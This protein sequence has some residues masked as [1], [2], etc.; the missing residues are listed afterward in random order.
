MSKDDRIGNKYIRYGIVTF[1]IFSLLT[2]VITIVDAKKLPDEHSN[3]GDK[4]SDKCKDCHDKKDVKSMVSKSVTT[5]DKSVITVDK[6]VTSEYNR[7]VMTV[8]SVGSTLKGM[9]SSGNYTTL[10]EVGQTPQQ[11]GI[12]FRQ[13]AYNQFNGWT[14]WDMIDF[15]EEIQKNLIVLTIFDNSTGTIKPIAGLT[16]A[17]IW[18]L[19]SFRNHSGVYSYKADIAL[20]PITGQT[21][22]PDQKDI[23]MIKEI[24]LTNI[25]SNTDLTFWTWYSMEVDWDYGYVMVSTDGG[26]NWIN[27]P[28]TYTNNTNPNG[29]NNGN[30]ITGSSPDWVQETMDLTPYIGNKIFLGFRFK[31]DAA[32][33]GEGLYI[34][35][36]S[37]TSGGITIFS[38]DAEIIPEIKTLSVNVTYPY[39][40]IGNLTN[41]LTNNA[42][43]QYTQ[44]VQKVDMYEVINHPGTY[45]GYFKYDTFGGQYPGT[46]DIMLDTYINNDHII[47]T[48][49]FQ[50]TT[51][52]CIGCHNKV[53]DNEETSFLHGGS[54]GG[55]MGSCMYI[56]HS[57]S[58]G[59]YFVPEITA[60]PMHLHEMKYGHKNGFIPGA[61]GNPQLDYNVSSH[62]TNT[63]CQECH[64]SFIHDNTGTDIFKI[65][66]YTIYGTNVTFSGGTHANL[67]CEY[68]HGNLN[69]P[70][71]PQSQHVLNGVLGDY[72]PSF[73]SH[74][75][76]A[77][78]YVIDVNGNVNLTINITG[79]D[80]SKWVLLHLVGPV[81]NTT[82][83]LQGSYGT[84]KG[85]LEL[86]QSLSTPIN[87][88]IPSPYIGTW[89]AKINHLQEGLIN[90]TIESNYPIERKPI[91]K[92]PECNECHNS[93]AVGNANTQ[94]EIPKW[95]PGFAHADTN[96]DG[97]LDIQ[98]RMCHDSMHNIGVK[99]CKDCHSSAPIG[100]FVQ[101]PEYSQYTVSQCLTCHGDP[102]RVIGGSGSCVDC[103]SRDVNIS[104]FGRHA[105]LN[106]SDGPGIVSDKDC[107]TCHHN[108]DMNK[109][110]IYLCE[111]CHVGGNG[112]VQ[113]TDPALIIGDFVHGPQQCKNCHA[114]VKYHM[115]GTVGPKGLMDLFGFN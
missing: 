114:P 112:I 51:L 28:G 106:T 37:I 76:F 113:V 62:V 78:T 34:D 110:N 96:G 111:S 89:I 35:D 40:I 74:E 10:L 82:T 92:I 46:Y 21:N 29:N 60:N 22:Y 67:D 47:S 27:L 84:W 48:T 85:P 65:A 101:E 86:D 42:T 30:G 19:A 3:V 103:H 24:D 50:T 53:N 90:Y 108:K 88:D 59:Y 75:S 1:L 56:C 26:T 77:D 17:P 38:D 14:W 16:S 63:T 6:P 93:R 71:I 58:R 52:G 31:S 105:N 102:H 44:H 115:N 66:N 69:Y 18:P 45:V 55:G 109:N 13:N 5:V 99:N 43:F 9:S 49:S 79:Q 64:T 54:D 32:V 107:W 72:E 25:V 36:I 98:C 39:M 70:D 83:A 41:P 8:K 20:S 61:W 94:Y 104:K 100:H 91:I 80:T 7:N 4:K 23:W 97:S 68:C 11:M 95:N 2:S 81:D 87:V 33:N 57:G 12:F 73:T 15:G